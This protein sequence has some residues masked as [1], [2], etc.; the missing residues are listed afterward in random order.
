MVAVGNGVGVLVGLGVGVSVAVS[1]GVDVGA[2]CHVMVSV[3]DVATT[4]TPR[5]Y[6]TTTRYSLVALE[7]DCTRSSAESAP[8]T[9]LH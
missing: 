2:F 8:D 1:V 5:S 7:S 3:E 9:S 6:E 4:G